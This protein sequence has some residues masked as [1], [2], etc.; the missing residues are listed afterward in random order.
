MRRAV[1]IILPLLILGATS[2]AQGQSA[3]TDAESGASSDFLKELKAAAEPE[4]EPESE[5]EP[6]ALESVADDSSE[7]DA[8][9]ESAAA[10]KPVAGDKPRDQ[11]ALRKKRFLYTAIGL[12]VLGA[13][14][15]AYGLYENSN[16]SKH[17]KQYS[18]NG[19]KYYE[20]IPA[21]EKAGKMRDAAYII[22]SVFLA[23]GITVHILF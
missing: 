12:D 11:Q 1:T 14:V 4:P 5:P 19:K 18:K 3:S 13:G 21:A 20:D 6:S 9:A 10:V 16:V 2:F 22:G 7:E 23:S 15:I 17:T 8:V